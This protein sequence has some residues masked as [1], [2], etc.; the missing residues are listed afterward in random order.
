MRIWILE[1][2]YTG[3]HRTWADGYRRHS[4][5]EI[6]LHTLDGHFWKWRMHGAA[7]TFARQLSRRQER[8]DLLLAT[9]MLN[10][11]YFLAL[12]RR[13]LA[14][15]PVVLYLHENQ[16]T[17]P[18]PPGEKRDLHYGFINYASALAADR[19]LFNS[20]HHFEEFF[21]ELPRLLKHFPDH[22]NLGTVEEIREKSAV[23]PV[24]CDLSRFDGYRL[25]DEDLCSSVPLILWNHRWEYDKDPET[26]FG[27]LYRLADE[28]Y[29]FRLAIAGESF[30]RVP[31]EFE[32][33]KERL[34]DR[35][36]HCGYAEGVEA[37]ARLLWR[38]HVVISTAIHEFFGIAVV[39]AIYCGCYPL[40]PNRLTYPEILPQK[41]W[42]EHLYQDFED[43]LR[44]LRTFLATPHQ[45]DTDGLR[46][47][48]RRF[49]WPRIVGQY[50]RL[51]EDVA[52][53][54]NR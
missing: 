17:Y 52:S 46:R 3:S 4:R 49:D 47:A 2:Y 29:S 14:G 6:E 35:M 41:A 8:P 1:P 21:D 51:M 9:D 26:F 36:V 10:L 31:R 45:G 23:L 16:L 54:G 5:H 15:I 7:I 22:N 19:V 37:Y 38:S 40:L 42:S 50:D 12:T 53:Q 30:R 27:A 13:S 25:D 24:G 32:E 20:H 33:A 28:G 44:R 43:L 18:F 48:M 34:G 11:P 39:E